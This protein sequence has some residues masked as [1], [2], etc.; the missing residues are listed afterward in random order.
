MSII[1]RRK[2]LPDFL[3]AYHEVIAQVRHN[4]AH[5]KVHLARGYRA[6]AEARRILYE[7][8]YPDLESRD[9]ARSFFNNSQT[10]NN[11]C[12]QIQKCD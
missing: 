11:P 3:S 8:I 4:A 9:R 10:R 2:A 7:I 6:A 1:L 12:Y 5:G